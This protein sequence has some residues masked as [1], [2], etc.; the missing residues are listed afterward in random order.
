LIEEEVSSGDDAFEAP[1]L[2][3]EDAIL[4]PEMEVN[5]TVRDSKNVAA[6]AQAF[7]ERNLVV[8]IPATGPEGIVG[9][10]GTLVLLRGMV[11]AKGGGTQSLSKGLWRVRVQ[12]VIGEEPYVRV[13][14]SRA[15][16]GEDNALA[17]KSSTME[18]VFRQIDEF[19]KLMPG[20]PEEIIAFLKTV[21]KPGKLADI[22]AY[23]PFFTMDERL[24]LLRTLDAEERLKKVNKLFEKQLS[25]LRG[26]SRAS[27][28]L[29]CA[30]CIELADR[31]FEAGDKG[32]EKVAREFLSHVVRDHP[33]ELLALLAEKYGPAFLS[34]RALR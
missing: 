12:N 18:A 31:A 2:F 6:A 22:C 11:P 15:G 33:G 4:F 14:F 10:I 3:A 28:I 30:T 13:R 8:M 20:I 1:A 27:I 21:D 16:G 7:R 32:G 29:D 5:I 19:V 17:G 24:D 9:S 23:S 25:D 34:R 26:S